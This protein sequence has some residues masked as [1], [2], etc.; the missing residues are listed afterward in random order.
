VKKLLIQW[1]LIICVILVVSNCSSVNQGLDK[2][3]EGAEEVGKPV[4]KVM[5]LPSSVSKGAAEGILHKEDEDN[6]FNR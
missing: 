6:P 1:S 4:G 5:N 2:A 3:N